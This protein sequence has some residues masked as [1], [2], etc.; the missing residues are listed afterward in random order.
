MGTEYEFETDK[1]YN[2]EGYVSMNIELKKTCYSKGEIIHGNL[3]LLPKNTSYP[4]QI[5]DP[6]AE[7]SLREQHF[8]EYNSRHYDSY[9]KETVITKRYEEENVILLTQNMNFS[10]NMDLNISNGSIIPFEIKVPN[11]AYPSCFFDSTSYVKH[12][13]SISFPS[14]GAKKTVIIIIKNGIY[15][16]SYNGLLKTPAILKNEIT[17]HKYIFFNYGSFKFSITLPKNIYSYDENVQFLIEIDCPNLSIN[18]QGIKVSLYRIY[19]KNYQRNHQTN[20]T[21]EK[22]DLISKYISLTEGEKHLHIED[23]IKLPL[24]Y[25]PKSIYSKLDNDNRRYKDKFKNIKLFPSC[26]GGL[27]TCEYFIKF[28]FD[29]DSWFTTN[30]EFSLPLDFYELFNDFTAEPKKFELNPYETYQTN[31]KNNTDQYGNTTQDDEFPDEN[32]I[33]MNKNNNNKDNNNFNKPEGD[34]NPDGDAPPPSAGL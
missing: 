16:S 31:N 34:D 27:L 26:Y 23:N 22:S 12:F 14:I 20:R 28:V 18:I 4:T 8:Y 7:I 29:L 11:T 24:D 5:I 10:N 1:N 6:Y 13:L 33:Y 2:Y 15:F 25:N 30:E 21:K 9:K 32:E 17:K 3:Y 19:K